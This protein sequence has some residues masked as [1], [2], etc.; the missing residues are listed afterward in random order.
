MRS[1]F[2]GE[3]EMK[4]DLD[5]FVGVTRSRE[6]ELREME[7]RMKAVRW[8]Y[9][10]EWQTL[11]KDF[12]KKIQ[13]EQPILR[14]PVIPNLSPDPRDCFFSH[15]IL[16]E[17]SAFPSDT[18]MEGDKCFLLLVLDNIEYCDFK[19]VLFY[20]HAVSSLREISMDL[21]KVQKLYSE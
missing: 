15:P 2:C 18:E 3:N 20:Y 10:E 9:L 5:L 6:E 19:G 11:F 8:V 4:E 7:K 21:Y 12:C 1:G 13:N 17:I 14:V 16:G